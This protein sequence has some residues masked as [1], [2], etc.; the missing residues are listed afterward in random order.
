M[1]E[2]K[3]TLEE[4]A[5]GS[6][7]H[8]DRVRQLVDCGLIRWDEHHDFEPA[9][10]LRIRRIERLRHDLGINLAGIEVVLN[11]LDRIR[12]MEQE[13]QELHSRLS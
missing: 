1:L 13:I 11:L 6:G 9:M 4:V 7:L 8:P 2:I 3:M 12:H 5:R 10:V